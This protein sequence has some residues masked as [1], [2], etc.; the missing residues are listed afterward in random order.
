MKLKRFTSTLLVLV[1]SLLFAAL[2]AAA[3]QPTQAAKPAA[4]ASAPLVDI[5]SASAAQLKALPGVG[6]AY[7]AKIIAGRPYAN[8]TQLMS[9]KIV[10]ASTYAKFSNLVIA[11]QGK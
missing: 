11:K 8:K 4:S 7:A 10:P 2:P 5:N 3:H 6:D 9:K 1:S